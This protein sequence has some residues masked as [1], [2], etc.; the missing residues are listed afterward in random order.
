MIRAPLPSD[1]HRRIASLRLLEILGT[2]PEERF[3]RITRLAKRLFHVPICAI[4]L[5]DAEREWLKSCQGLQEREGPR[6][7]SFCG[8][9]ILESRTLVIEDAM[10]D[11]RFSDNPLVAD[12]PKV[13]FYAGHPLTLADGSR[14]GALCLKDHE[15]RRFSEEERKLLEDLASITASELQLVELCDLR[16]QVR[17]RLEAEEERDRF[18]ALSQD[19]FCIA[20]A[21]GRLRGANPSW[22][23]ALGYAP[24]E[25]TGTHLLELLHPGDRESVLAG[26]SRLRAGEAVVSGESRFRRRE[27]SYSW[28]LWSSTAD[29]ERRLIFTSARD[30]T[31]RRRLEEDLAG[32]RDRVM[33]ASRLKSEFLATM[34]H[35][36]RTPMSG[37][38][39]MA[40]LLLETRLAP[41]QREMTAAIHRSANALLAT[42]NDIL[43]LSCI[44]AGRLTLEPAPFDLLRIVEDVTE[45]MHARAEDRGLDLV[46]RWTPKAPRRL[47]GDAGRVRQILLNLVENAIKFTQAGHVRIEVRREPS[48]TEGAGVRVSVEDTGIGIPENKLE[49]VFE[50]FTQADAST[51]RHYGG[52]GLGLAICRRLAELMHGRIGVESR[53][54]HGSRFW[55][56]LSLPEEPG[57]DGMADAVD[58]LRGTNVLVVD[59]RESRRRALE[60]QLR[61]WG[62]RCESMASGRGALEQM[63][64]ARERGDSFSVV[65]VD[66][67]SPESGGEDL[68]A[69]I[70]ADPRLRITPVVALAP[71]SK[72]I[73]SSKGRGP[74]VDALLIRPVRLEWLIDAL[75][76]Y[77]ERSVRGRSRSRSAAGNGATRRAP[78]QAA[79][80][81][82]QRHRV[83]VVVDNEVNRRVMQK[84]LESLGCRATVAASGREA[85]EKST[86]SCFDVILMDYQLPDMDGCEAARRI[87]ELE[88]TARRTPIVALTASAVQEDAQRCLSAGMDD[89]L[90]QPA[91]KSDIQACLERWSREEAPAR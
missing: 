14:V 6:D 84:I 58:R 16:K 21:D 8:H 24:E 76:S 43:D 26:H 75:V 74:R 62:V 11:P 79:T 27:G 2:P 52:T 40:G 20:D 46:L 1:E 28:L 88:G 85:L 42:L 90:S 87:R 4:S 7:I 72:A 15:P 37:V 83:L 23:K 19:L 25:L 47:I 56:S 50:K 5:L 38:I 29:P 17:E 9:T 61:G 35:E 39:G 44:E 69:R 67:T 30:I 55:L 51:T 32:A 54:G 63:R 71:A 45:L 33:E 89:H 70:K 91:Q 49:R 3:D 68:T 86:G 13:R 66:L 80:V 12:H 48:S 60:E 34:S 18:F 57:V 81:P 53:P 31:D 41:D 36:M 73:A 22:K 78:A 77:Q 10:S 59:G 64:K 65:L 82:A